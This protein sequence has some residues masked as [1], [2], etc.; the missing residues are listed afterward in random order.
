MR[1]AVFPA[2]NGLMHTDGRTAVGE[3]PAETAA[4]ARIAAQVDRHA[5][6]AS[7]PGPFPPKPPNKRINPF[8]NPRR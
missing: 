6:A 3:E 5:P 2:D 7:R 8:R 4:A 1:N